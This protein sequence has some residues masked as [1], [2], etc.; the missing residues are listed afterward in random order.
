M[1]DTVTVAVGV[2]LAVPAHLADEGIDFD[3]YAE[4]LVLDALADRAVDVLD[5]V[6]HSDPTVIFPED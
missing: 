4:R 5:S 6:A 2:K 1:S 3:A